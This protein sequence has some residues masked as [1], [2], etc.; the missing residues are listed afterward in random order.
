MGK[1]NRP[2]HTLD[3]VFGES[4]GVGDGEPPVARVFHS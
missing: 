2:K 3:K 4:A 1:K